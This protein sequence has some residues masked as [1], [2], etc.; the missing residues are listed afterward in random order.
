MDREYIR[1]LWEVEE[2]TLCYERAA[3]RHLSYAR[4]A[5]INGKPE[6]FKLAAGW[7]DMIENEHKDHETCGRPPDIEEKLMMVYG[8]LEALA[9]CARQKLC[10]FSRIVDMVEAIDHMT[11]L[12]FSNYLLLTRHRDQ[13]I[14]REWTMDGA[15]VDLVQLFEKHVF[16]GLGSALAYAHMLDT[17]GVLPDSQPVIKPEEVAAIRNKRTRCDRSPESLSGEWRTCT[18]VKK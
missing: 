12:S 16:E 6:S 13:H 2:F 7:W 1:Y 4:F 18:L 11:V 3:K 8:R 14:S 15:L 9:S 17:R 10:S 5:E